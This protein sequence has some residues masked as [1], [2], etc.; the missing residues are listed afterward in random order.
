MASIL[1]EPSM[2]EYAEDV[3][4]SFAVSVSSLKTYVQ[5]FQEQMIM[6]LIGGDSELSQIP[7]F[8]TKLPDGSEKV[9]FSFPAEN[10]TDCR[11]VFVFLLI[12]GAQT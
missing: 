7:T 9:A 11:R 6:G 8:I 5:S 2:E 10:V 4:Q 12:S 1:N 3:A